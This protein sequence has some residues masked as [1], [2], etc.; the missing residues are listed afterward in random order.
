MP[1]Q[2]RDPRAARSVTWIVIAYATLC[3]AVLGWVA[4][5]VVATSTSG[6]DWLSAAFIGPFLVAREMI[7]E[8][9]PISS[10][11]LC[12]A[13]FVI[14]C[15]ASTVLALVA[16]AGSSSFRAEIRVAA[17]FLC[18]FAV[19][20]AVALLIALGVVTYLSYFPLHMAGSLM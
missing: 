1:T 10:A 18:V 17:A 7:G 16:S 3:G 4:A 13:P 14:A 20:W 19:L 2:P 11:I 6:V 9:A 5:A 8:D 12:V 15:V